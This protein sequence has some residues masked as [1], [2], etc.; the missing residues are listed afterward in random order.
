MHHQSHTHA[1]FNELTLIGSTLIALILVAVD[2]YVISLDV[3]V[4]VGDLASKLLVL[5]LDSDL[6]V[7]EVD[8]GSDF[9]AD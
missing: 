9:L 8:V 7:C 3:R 6:E 1:I 4:Q 2:E 5:P